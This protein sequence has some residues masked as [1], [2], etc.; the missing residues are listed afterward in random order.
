MKL[1]LQDELPEAGSVA[2]GQPKSK[3][4]DL[5]KMAQGLKKRAAKKGA[6]KLLT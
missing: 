2:V 4:E 5:A 1:R 6:H 3:D